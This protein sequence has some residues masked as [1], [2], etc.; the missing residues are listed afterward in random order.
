MQA[1]QRRFE[2]SV[3][4]RLFAVPHR[5]QFFQAVRMIE[6]WF[7]RNGVPHERA[8]SD[9]VRFANRTVL[10]F[11]ASEIEAIDTYPSREGEAISVDNMEQAL[12]C[13]Q[14]KYVRIT[15]T[16]MGF[17]GSSGSLPAH[18]TERVAR[19]QIEHRDEGPRAFLDAFSTRS[20]AL[21]YHAWNKYRLTFHYDVGRRDTFLPLLLSLSGLGFHSLRQRL[22]D[23]TGNGVRDESL[24]YFA[25]ALR[26]RPPS[27]LYMQKVLGE[28]F[29]V[30]LQIEQFIGY[31]YK[32][33]R[34]H[35]TV[36]GSTNSVLGKAMVG[37]RV[38]Q[39]DLRM[40]LRIGP[41]A[42]RDFEKFLPGKEVSV[43][44]ARMLGMF[45]GSTLEYEV[46]VALLAQDVRG[47][48]L[49]SMREG[50]RLGWDSF[51]AT[52]PETRDRADLRYE[53]SVQ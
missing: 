33:P 44:L 20:L 51:V 27:A 3:I 2:P 14:M 26:H 10:G 46:E 5:F 36:L 50:G 22:Q 41:V 16:F 49:G 18:Y 1:T 32:V 12:R 23:G 39:R 29:S 31:W 24:G 8:V 43:A 21:F 35:Q 37:E 4:E 40:R 48:T 25:G 19:H 38:W 6:C 34:Q 11:P 53:I 42:I 7:R 13:G 9:F 15:P 52:A 47:M 45:S 17:L 30:P 28:Y